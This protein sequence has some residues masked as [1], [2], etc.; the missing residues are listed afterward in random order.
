M[1]FSEAV[2]V[3]ARHK[4]DLVQRGVRKLAIFGSVAR[5]EAKKRSDVDILVDYDA[6]YGLFAFVDLKMY[7]ENLL[8]C[9][10][11]LVSKSALHPALRKKIL[12]EAKD[13]F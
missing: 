12:Q 13:V 6:K 9:D 4:K 10:V 2:K 8:R 1:L 7:L 5:D 11:D 3:L